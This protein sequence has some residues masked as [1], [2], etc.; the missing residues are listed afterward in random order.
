MNQSIISNLCRLCATQEIN[1]DLA[2]KDVAS[3]KS[4]VA[5]I[6]KYLKIKIND[7]KPLSQK[8]CID[9]IQRLE[10][11]DVF[12]KKCH[13]VQD[14]LLTLF[15]GVALTEDHKQLLPA[16]F[17]DKVE[18]APVPAEPVVEISTSA[19]DADT[20]NFDDDFEY[21]DD[22]DY[23]DD[24][25]DDDDDYDDDTP[26]ALRAKRKAKSSS[27][28]KRKRGRPRKDSLKVPPLRIKAVKQKKSVAFT[29]APST[30][31]SINNTQYEIRE[32]GTE[33]PSDKRMYFLC[34]ILKSSF[35]IF[36][37]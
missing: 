24:P 11:F 16:D 35:C 25:Y 29:D 26:L 13:S 36:L 5:L 22:P 17:L 18:Y 14:L 12:S 37:C 9:C 20:N 2:E 33:E 1:T 30:S 28:P 8:F 7:K 4:I 23:Q 31:E 21:P 34:T 15:E 32:D 10:T 19:N 27:E 6:A 3:K